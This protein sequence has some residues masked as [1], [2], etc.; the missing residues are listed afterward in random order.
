MVVRFSTQQMKWGEGH[1]EGAT[2]PSSPQMPLRTRFPE[3]FFK[4]P[5]ELGQEPPCLAQYHMS[6]IPSNSCHFA[7]E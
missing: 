6:P 5:P 2:S 7:R 4:E 3:S 1:Q